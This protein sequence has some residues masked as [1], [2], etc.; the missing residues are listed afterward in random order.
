MVF[1]RHKNMFYIIE[2][3]KIGVILNCIKLKG[4][5]CM[6]LKLYNDS[7]DG[8]ELFYGYLGGYRV[9]VNHELVERIEKNNIDKPV[10]DILISLPIQNCEIVEI[11]KNT[12]VLVPG[13]KILYYFESSYYEIVQIDCDDCKTYSGDTSTLILA[14]GK[15]KLHCQCTEENEDGEEETS[16]MVVLLHP[17]G[18]KDYIPD[19]KILEYV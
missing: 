18:K 15:V 2:N 13:N 1:I 14:T 8:K 11:D 3:L 6:E 7:F 16:K 5:S 4:G 12:L 10:A 19:E 17:D 9:Y